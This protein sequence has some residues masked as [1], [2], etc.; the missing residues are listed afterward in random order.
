MGVDSL[1]VVGKVHEYQ[2]V[3]CDPSENQMRNPPEIDHPT[4]TMCRPFR[5]VRGKETQRRIVDD[6]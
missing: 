6:V 1:T 2:D 3:S 4:T 5:P